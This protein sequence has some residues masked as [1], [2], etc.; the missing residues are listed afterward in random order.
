MKNNNEINNN[1]NTS[2]RY[3]LF[4][5]IFNNKVLFK[6]IYNYVFIFQKYEKN[7]CVKFKSREEIL[8][9]KDREYISKIIY[10]EEI[11][12][13]GDLP[14]N[15]N[16]VLKEIEFGGYRL[17][18]LKSKS[19]P[20]H[21]ECINFNSM[22]PQQPTQFH[23]LP[24]SVFKV[25]GVVIS[26]P[27]STTSNLNPYIPS[28]IKSISLN[29]CPNISNNND[30]GNGY[31]KIPTT[32]N[33]LK[34][35]K[36]WD[37]EGIILRNG[38]IPNNITSLSIKKYAIKYINNGLL[39][40]SIKKLKIS[41]NES[42]IIYNNNNSK[43][44]LFSFLPNNLQILKINFETNITNN[45]KLN[46]YLPSTINKLV[47]KL[48]LINII[49]IE[50]NSIILNNNNNNLNDLI[51]FNLNVKLK[52]NVIPNVKS[53]K[54]TWNNERFKDRGDKLISKYSIPN[55]VTSLTINRIITQ[56]NTLPT[57]LTN[58]EILQHPN[59][60]KLEDTIKM[61]KIL[62]ESL[63]SIILPKEFENFNLSIP[64]TVNLITF[65]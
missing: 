28:S 5:K 12:E 2:Y 4:K 42:D 32:L 38:D 16:Q 54:L 1:K 10:L 40:N 34:F 37:N 39:S 23:S 56:P 44:D 45:L 14:D 17:K 48:S 64:S 36:G 11:I 33:E 51:I 30:N 61:M 29:V 35:K 26:I 43:D 47:L 60:Y 31:F 21:V 41:C 53:L 24:S 18:R 50:P 46:K 20:N 63:T 62:P 58:L 59:Y 9:Y 7:K 6:K 8:K 3:N 15:N 27:K 52:E 25:K 13:I 49:N 57:S 55:S 65:K 22:N 19:I